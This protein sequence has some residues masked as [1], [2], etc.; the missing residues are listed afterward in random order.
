MS[1]LYV[2]GSINMD[3]VMDTDIVPQSGVTVTGNSFMTNPGGKGANQAVA[4]AKSGGDVELIACV[5][6]QF[7]S[8]LIDTLKQYDVGVNKV[9]RQSGVSSGVA[10]VILSGGDN[11]IILDKGSNA[12][13]DEKIVE[14]SLNSANIGDY[15]VTQLEI[16]CASVMRAMK[17]GKSKKLITVLNPAPA[18]ELPEEIWQ[19]VDYFI[20]N[21]SE[22]EFYTGIYPTDLNEAQH[23]AK[24][25]QQKGV[26]NVV[27]TMGCLGAVAVTDSQIVHVPACKVSAVDTTAAGDTFVGALATMLSEGYALR[28]AMTYANKAAA[29]TVSRSG[30]Q[31]SIPYRSEIK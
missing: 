19:Y 2:V 4:I 26:K 1:K 12:L 6:E 3:L 7:G 18:A 9:V 30:A 17:I 21:Q 25:L 31:Q 24:I 22:T 10:I 14:D 15:V 23:A 5:G 16:P 27:I 11:R 8:E 13:V 29:I 28:E 20:P